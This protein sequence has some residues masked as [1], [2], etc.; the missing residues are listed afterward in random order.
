VSRVRTI[1]WRAFLGY[2]VAEWLGVLLAYAIALLSFAFL[3]VYIVA[4]AMPGSIVL[5]GVV[6]VLSSAGLYMLWK[7]LGVPRALFRLARWGTSAEPGRRA[8]LPAARTRVSARTVSWRA[9]P[10]ANRVG[11]L[12]GLDERRLGARSGALSLGVAELKVRDLS[13]YPRLRPNVGV[14]ASPFDSLGRIP[15]RSATEPIRIDP[16]RI[17]DLANEAPTSSEPPPR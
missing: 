9:T 16:I 4:L 2:L 1:A 5:V 8:G 14:A 11:I 17:V 3:I 6:V 13:P 15:V 10:V 12:T 7:A